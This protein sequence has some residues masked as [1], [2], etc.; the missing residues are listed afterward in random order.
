MPNFV[1]GMKIY[2][3]SEK[4]PQFV[5]ANIEINCKELVEFM[6]ANHKDGK[7]RIDIKE[8]KQKEDGT[9]GN[10]YADLNTYEATKSPTKS[11]WAKPEL[12]QQF[13]SKDAVK[14]NSRQESDVYGESG[15]PKEQ[16][17]IEVKDIPF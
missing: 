9:R 13:G 5:K 15:Y 2:R 1:N 10:L 17:M 7:I 12:R 3:P 16:E 6:R 11:D 4:A 8:G 14:P